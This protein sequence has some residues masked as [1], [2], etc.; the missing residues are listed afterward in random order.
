VADTGG[1]L[2][3]NC[4]VP[5]SLFPKPQWWGLGGGGNWI[6]M[7]LR[8]WLDLSPFPVFLCASE[9][10]HTRVHLCVHTRLM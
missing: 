10:A 7:C 5:F 1:C 2:S 6:A 8:G 3:S 9:C 4:P